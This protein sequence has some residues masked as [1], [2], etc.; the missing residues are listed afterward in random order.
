MARIEFMQPRPRIQDWCVKI[1]GRAIGAVW[2][3]GDSFR[4]S[5]G[6]TETAPTLDDAFKAAKKQIKALRL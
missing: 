2:K 6:T 1:D 3:C 5:V 4:V